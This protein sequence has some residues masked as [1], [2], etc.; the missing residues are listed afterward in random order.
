VSRRDPLADPEPLI[1]QVYGYIA[2]R[3]GPG[4]DADDVTSETFERAVKYRSSYDTRKG[5]PIAWLIAIA[6]RCANDWLARRPP[7]AV[8][9]DE[10]AGGG[11]LAEEV[12]RR[13]DLDSAVALLSERDRGLIALRFG[14]DLSAR[15]IAEL[16]GERTNT[17]EVALSRALDRLRGLLENPPPVR[18]AG[19]DQGRSI[20]DS[21]V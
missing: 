12:A 8:E 1:R 13:L 19:G 6:R 20:R 11:E 18:P 21:P 4:P 7:T 9:L 17:I 16:L 14:A 3:I 5:P 2:Y 10:V 15:Q